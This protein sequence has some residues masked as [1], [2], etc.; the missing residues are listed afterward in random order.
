M[1]GPYI[2]VFL[3]GLREL[4]WIEQ[5]NIV[6]EWCHAAGDTG[7]LKECA[8]EFERLK[9]DVV[10]TVASAA[11]RAMQEVT[12]IVPIVFLAT[13]DPVGQRFVKSLSHPGGNITG[14]SF[15]ATADITAKQ[16]QLL[17]EMVPGI[18][19]VAVLWNPASALLRSYWEAARAKGPAL[20]VALDSFEVQEPRQFESTFDAMKAAQAGALIVLSDSFSLSTGLASRNSL[21]S[22]A[23]QQS[24][25][26]AVTLPWGVA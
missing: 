6:I 3:S 18:D 2:D 16:V 23:Y 20:G 10:V 14:V 5:K 9:L 15:D 19:R 7:K 25:G 26:T 4:G 1:R 22:T 17:I 8:V 24:M 12:K 21:R 13:G 11:T